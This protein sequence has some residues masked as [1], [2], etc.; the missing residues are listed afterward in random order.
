M[1][2][3]IEKITFWINCA[4]PYSIPITVLSWLVIFVYSIKQN[5]NALSGLIALIG[6]I[7]VHLSTNLADDYFDYKVLSAKDAINNAKDCKCAYLRK[8]QATIKDLRNVIITFLLIAA[9]IGIILFF[10]SGPAVLLLAIIGLVIALSYSV[11]SR[12]GLGEIAVIIAYGPLMFEGVYYVMTRTFSWNVL[13]LSFAC[14][15]FTNSI[16]YA[17]MLMD[18]DEDVCANKKTLCI[19]LG[20]KTNA[21]NFILVFYLLGYILMGYLSLKT[22]N[23]LYFMTYFTIPLVIDLY[24]SLKIYNKD[25]TIVPQARFWNFPLDNWNENQ[26]APSAPFYLR[27]FYVRNISTWFM[28]LTCI[29]IIFG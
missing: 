3:F 24:Y 7:L 21:L 13:I 10:I 23:Y 14:V 20:N 6:I 26:K 27:F 5:G 16:L 4:R 25:K 8:N 18:F 17:H 22:H 19:R 2:K 15:M 1:Q 12:N 9:I 28:L 11:F 29:A